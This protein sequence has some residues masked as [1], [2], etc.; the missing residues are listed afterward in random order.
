MLQ[1]PKSLA[2]CDG[3]N[4]ISDAVHIVNWVFNGGDPPCCP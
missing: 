2:N 3:N 4:N 1:H